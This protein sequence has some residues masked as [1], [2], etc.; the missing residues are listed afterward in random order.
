[1]LLSTS[2]FLHAAA[3]S[4]GVAMA[5]PQFQHFNLGLPLVRPRALGTTFSQ[6]QCRY[7]GL[8][9]QEVFKRICSLKF[10][11]I[12]LCSYWNEIE[13]VENQFDFTTIDWLLEESQRQGI[14]VVLTVGMKAPR[15]PEF[16]FPDWVSARYDTSGGPEPVDQRSPIAD[17]ALNFV[18]QVIQHTRMAPTLTYWQ[19]ENEPFTRLDITAGRFLSYEFVR[20]EVQRVRSQMRPDQ[21]LLMTSAITLPAAQLD[22]DEHAFQESLALADAVGINVYTKVPAGNSFIYLQPLPSYWQKLRAWQDHLS[23]NG[24]EDWIAEA[25]AEPWEPNKL[26]AMDKFN[27]PSSSPRQATSLVNRVAEM[28]YSTVMLWGCE[29]WYWQKKNGHNLWWHTVEKLVNA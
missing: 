12:R 18:S 11:R 8:D 15:W 25:Q 20:R 6:L 16:H 1:M 14:E 17:Q 27:H 24:K 23:I 7:M 28:G 19:V 5:F 26:V 9:Y 29:Y 4:T 22:E 10:D 2:S 3:A 21:K 13:P